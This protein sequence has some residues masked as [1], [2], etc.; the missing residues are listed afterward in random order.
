MKQHQGFVIAR[1]KSADVFFTS[2][3]SYDYPK[4]ITVQEAT[5]YPTAELAQS[6]ATKLWKYGNYSATV[7]ALSEAMPFQPPRSIKEPN[8]IDPSIEPEDDISLDQPEIGSDEQIDDPESEMKA[9]QGEDFDPDEVNL[10]DDEIET[11]DDDDSEEFS[12]DELGEEDPDFENELEP[13]DEDEFDGEDEFEAAPEENEISFEAPIERGMRQG[14]RSKYPQGQGPNVMGE[15][16]IP[17][18]VTTIKYKQ[19]VN[20]PADVN[21]SDEIGALHNPHKT[22][23]DILKSLKDDIAEFEKVY[24]Y[25]NGKD[26]SQASMALTISS[27]MK[28]LLTDLEQGTIEG[29]TQAQIRLQTYMGP[30]LTNI[31]TDVK[32]YLYKRGRQPIK[33]KNIFYDKWNTKGQ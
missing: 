31:P 15:S 12:D 32:D 9:G 25:N 28:D 27:A 6:A 7:R 24:E 1:N 14:T 4:W 26:D 5:V 3:S 17:T 21:F 13:S 18:D 30:I 2:G 29:L 10:D 23:A 16:G 8:P 19:Q 11:I 20:E 22:P 33:L